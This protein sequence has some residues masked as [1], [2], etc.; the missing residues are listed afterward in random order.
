MQIKWLEDFRELAKTRSF[1]RAAENRSV[2]HPA[3][4]RRIRALE[5]WVGTALVDRG[6]QPVAL[7]P[8]GRLF[9]DAASNAIDDLN[10][11][12]WLL[13]EVQLPVAL[14]IGTGRTLARTFV[15]GWYQ[16][17]YEQRGPFPISVTTGGTQGGV[18]E[19]ADGTTDLLISYASPQ[20]DAL[21]DPRK[22]DHCRLDSET[23]VP[24]SIPDK[25]GHPRFRLPGSAGSPLPWLAFSRGLTLRQILDSHLAATDQKA[26]LTPVFQA[27]FYEAVEEM[28]LRGFGMAWLPHR[29]VKNDLGAGALCLAGVKEWNIRVDISMYR[30]RS[31]Q[32]A[33]LDEVWKLAIANAQ[34]LG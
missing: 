30:V 5:E 16:D 9:L 1:S 8:A 29:L 23:L 6:V 31:N 7:T 4:G 3:F 24:V 27:D 32:N 10:E 12:R 15:P 21:L 17:L 25:R 2:T 19:L 22:Y 26:F 13:R 11:A 34:R 20:A 14:K 28:A 33:L 18:L